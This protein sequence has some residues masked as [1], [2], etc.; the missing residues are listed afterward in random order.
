MK[1]TLI[2]AALA[3]AT[4][5]A[6]ASEEQRALPPEVWVLK[7]TF[8][9]PVPPALTGSTVGPVALA[10]VPAM[11][12]MIPVGECQKGIA[13]VMKSAKGDTLMEQNA[14]VAKDGKTR[15]VLASGWLMTP[16]VVRNVPRANG[17]R[18]DIPGLNYGQTFA[19]QTN[20]TFVSASFGLYDVELTRVFPSITASR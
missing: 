17:T 14:C 4:L 3:G 18:A 1:R 20:G 16:E 8:R 2:F 11:E 10:K 6:Y 13:R 7:A 5:F 15:Q 9:E 19:I 12:F